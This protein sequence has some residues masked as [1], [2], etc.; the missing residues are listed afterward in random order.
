MEEVPVPGLTLIDDWIGKS[1]EDQLLGLVDA[2]NWRNDLKR[3]VQHFG[4]RYDYR[5][6]SVSLADHLGP[7]PGW[8][9]MLAGRLVDGGAF[10]KPPDQVI[11]NE[12]L[13]GQ[14]ISA[15]IDCV[16]C[17]GETIAILS[18]GGS[19][20]MKFQCSANGAGRELTLPNCSL[21]TLMGPAR[22]DW[23]HAIP[24][25]MSDVIDGVKTP[26]IRRVSLT[27]RSVNIA[28]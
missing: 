3:R 12:Y 6:R 23:L 21:L 19:T 27:F 8:L 20:V 2:G 13:P 24:A 18:L 25:R 16:P 11:I 22:Y 17:F 4:Y 15:H 28:A 7:L 1:D 26:R 9:A 14:G 10:S 5:A